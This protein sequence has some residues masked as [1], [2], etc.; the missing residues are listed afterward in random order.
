MTNSF[1]TLGLSDARV[2]HLEASG[3]TIPTEIQSKAIPLLLQGRDVVGQS[4]TGTG[5]TAAFLLPVIH[6]IISSKQD[7]FIKA[8]INHNDFVT[9]R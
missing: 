8:L 4:Q 9:L 1:R 3:F 6:K 2:E 5:K 7:D